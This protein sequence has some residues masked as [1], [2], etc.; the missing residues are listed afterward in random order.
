[1][2]RWVLARRGVHG[3]PELLKDVLVADTIELLHEAKDVPPGL[4][5]EAVV[6]LLVDIDREGRRL[7]LMEG[8]E[9]LE[10]PTRRNEVD[11]VVPRQVLQRHAGTDG[12]TILRTEKDP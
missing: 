10:L 2:E 5:A 8:T 4:A 11:V 12:L 6:E 3:D 1:M 7:F 9:R